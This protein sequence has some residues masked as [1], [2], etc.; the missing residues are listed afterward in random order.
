MIP[1]AANTLTAEE[2]WETTAFGNHL[3]R[4]H[5]FVFRFWFPDDEFAN[6]EKELLAFV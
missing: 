3:F 5:H 4:K 6:L 2:S 1:V